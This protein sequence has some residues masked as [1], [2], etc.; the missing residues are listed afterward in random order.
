M[1]A[2]YVLLKGSKYGKKRHFLALNGV[3][4][5]LIPTNLD[6]G[7]ETKNYMPKMA[8]FTI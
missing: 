5:L 3:F 2:K 8:V 6:D 1:R 4:L 7:A